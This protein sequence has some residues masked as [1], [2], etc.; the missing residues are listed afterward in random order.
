MLLRPRQKELVNRAVEALHRHGN[1]LAVAP[2]GA[3][4][5]IMLSAA[6]GEMFKVFPLKVCVLAHRDEL[7]A[8][9]V[10]KFSLV[11]PHLSTS[12]VDG[13]SKS[14]EGNTTFAMAQTLSR[15]GNLGAMP[16]LDLLVI[17]EAHHARSESYLR[18]ISCAK[19]LNPSLKVLGM[20]A[21]PNRGDKRGLHPVF[22]NV[23]DQITVKELIASGHLVTPRTFVMD[24]GA[25]EGLKQVQKSAGDYDMEEVAQIMNT[26]PVNEA[27]VAHWQE[28]AAD[29]QTVVFCSTV[30]HARHVQNSFIGGGVTA[31][32]VHGDMLP[33]EREQALELYATGKA[34]VIV[35]VAVLTEGWDHPPTSCV[36]LLRPSF[37]KST[38]IQMIGR[39]LRPLNPQEYPGLIKKDCLVLDFGTAT[40]AHG[41]IEQSVQLEDQLEDGLAPNKTCPECE[42]EVPAAVS[43]CPLCGF[44][45]VSRKKEGCRNLG[46][47]DFVLAE[48]DILRRSPFLWVA[49]DN[50]EHSF[51]AA[52][53]NAWGGVFFGVDA[54]G[55]GQWHA[56]GA[57]Q[58]QQAK[59]LAV[60]DKSV[61]FA[62][63]NDWMNLHES[64]SNAHKAKG[65]LKLAPT[66]N[67]LQYLP[68]HQGDYNMTRYKASALI[69]LKFNARGIN[70]AI[71][72]ALESHASSM[73]EVS[74]G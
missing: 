64:D 33:K 59:L 44:V 42:G 34:Q 70:M 52:G 22:S 12:V 15:R 28:K 74:Y 69:N 56:V 29:R 66:A 50:R 51:I 11:N 47:R 40:L 72:N 41:S 7:A 65:W 16:C 21:T 68:E 60:G 71:N 39:G 35:N 45:F 36:V 26:R 25:Q 14:W 32:L 17:D 46:V 6:I 30:D 31:V 19:A 63:A 3:G 20:T 67:Q 2:T 54:S 8:Q 61:C 27:V 37:H 5:T 49:V 58:K 48:I 53:F 4:K 55:S 9:N 43:S 18:I 38:M 24:V 62:A 57:M 13:D 73:K 1:T 23:C 10:A